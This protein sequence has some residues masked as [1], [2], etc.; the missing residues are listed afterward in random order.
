MRIAEG[1]WF[2]PGH[3]ECVVGRSLAGKYPSARIGQTMRFGRGDYTVVGVMEHGKSAVNSE[4]WADTNQVGA[5]YNRT[6]VLSSALFRAT[7]SNA[8]HM[9]V[10]ELKGDQRLNVDAMTEK[11]YYDDQTSSGLPLQFI[12]TMVAVI[13]AVG[14]CFAAMNTMYAAVARRAK[15][16]GT[17]RV[18]GFSKSGIL[19]SFF[20]E[21]VL[22]SLLGGLIG[23]LLVLPLSN[24]NTA[25]GSMTSFTEVSFE[26]RITPDIIFFGVLFG[27]LMGVLGGIFPA[28]AAARKQILT[29][30]RE[31]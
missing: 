11:K 20:L 17:L 15:E 8:V 10:N 18:L 4:I 16:I 13:M 31:V 27:V 24:V 25:V 28:A 26:F 14:S 21:S 2:R 19:A 6:E 5:D 3:R 9:L 1:R 30:L 12:G 29:A 7:D 23:V 22:L